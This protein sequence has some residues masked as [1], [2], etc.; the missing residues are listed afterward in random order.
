MKTKFLAKYKKFKSKGRLNGDR[1]LLE[2][3]D[4]ATEKKTKGG[5]IIAESEHIRSDFVM[6]KSTVA[7]VLE[8]GEGYF[9]PDTKEDIP[10]DTKVGQVVWVPSQSISFL[11]TVPGHGS[12]LPEKCIALGSESQIIKSWDNISDYEADIKKFE[13]DKE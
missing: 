1:L 11:T 6:L 13:E 3:I 2:V 8:V 5:I 10:L 12:A 4:E 7:V 9:D